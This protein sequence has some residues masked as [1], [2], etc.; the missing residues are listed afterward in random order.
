MSRRHLLAAGAAI[1]GGLATSPVLAEEVARI[2]LTPVL[3]D[4]D[5]LLLRAAR[6]LL[7][8]SGR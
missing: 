3:L 1:A 7:M 4:S 8:E 5:M 6:T 2:G